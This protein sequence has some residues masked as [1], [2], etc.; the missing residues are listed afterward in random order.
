MLC[1]WESEDRLARTSLLALPS[2]GACGCATPKESGI[3]VLGARA[4]AQL[5]LND[6]GLAWCVRLRG[7]LS[8]RRVRDS[9]LHVK[10]RHLKGGLLLS[11]TCE[12]TVTQMGYDVCAEIIF[13]LVRSVSLG[14]R[15][16]FTF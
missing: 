16:F 5:R 1:E 9:G 15:R 13:A 11:T 10:V 8:S 4:T 7:G 2:V 3:E 6:R 12:L 14:D